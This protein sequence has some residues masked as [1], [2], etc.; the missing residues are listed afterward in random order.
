MMSETFNSACG[1]TICRLRDG[2]RPERDLREERLRDMVR[3]LRV[4]GVP[5]TTNEH[6]LPPQTLLP[7]P[8]RTKREIGRNRAAQAGSEVTPPDG[9]GSA[10]GFAE[11]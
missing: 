5:Q 3:Y 1:R 6:W 8:A 11:V 4:W 9:A 2:K 10:G 7:H